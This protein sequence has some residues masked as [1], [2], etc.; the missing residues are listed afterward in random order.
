MSSSLPKIELKILHIADRLKQS[1]RPITLEILFRLAERKI[2][3]SNKEISRS[4]Y[5][6]ILKNQLIIGSRLTRRE[7]MLKG[8]RYQI[9]QY[10]V[11][12]LNYKYQELN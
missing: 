6:L 9:Y 11:N 5:N 10:I 8:K 7:T 3:K 1:N 12:L 2:A 4:I